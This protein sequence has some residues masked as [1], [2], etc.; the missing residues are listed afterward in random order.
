MEV[1]PSSAVGIFS[2]M[3]K[4][5][6]NLCTFFLQK[7]IHQSVFRIFTAMKIRMHIH[8]DNFKMGN[9]FK[10]KIPSKYGPRPSILWEAW[11]L[12]GS[13]WY[14]TQ[15]GYK[16]LLWPK[17]ICMWET[18]YWN[19]FFDSSIDVCMYD[20]VLNVEEQSNSMVNNPFY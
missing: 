18:K 3:K 7:E 14:F 11:I 9:Q 17:Q 5:V 4:N 10:I 1:V 19:F 2:Q 13:M 16:Q 20:T 6:Q 15:K 12:F 8:K